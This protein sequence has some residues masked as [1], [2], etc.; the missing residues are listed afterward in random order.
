MHCEYVLLLFMRHFKIHIEKYIKINAK[1][2][3]N[4]KISLICI[5]FIRNMY[6]S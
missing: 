1:K 3:S 6:L 4:A 5:V 2:L